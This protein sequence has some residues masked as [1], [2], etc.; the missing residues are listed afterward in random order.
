LTGILRK[1]GGFSNSREREEKEDCRKNHHSSAGE[2]SKPSFPF[3]AEGG[4]KENGQR[5]EVPSGDQIKKTFSEK[6]GNNKL[7]Q[8]CLT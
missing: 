5:R 6:K 4:G 2:T 8:G 7:G 1:Q 3:Q